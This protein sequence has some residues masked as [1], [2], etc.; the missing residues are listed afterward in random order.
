MKKAIIALVLTICLFIDSVSMQVDAEEN[1]EKENV[2][3][4]EHIDIG[5]YTVGNNKTIDQLLQQSKFTAR[6]GH[7][8]AA[9]IGNNLKLPTP[10]GV[11]NLEKSIL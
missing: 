5:A 6:Q 9:E 7:G 10:Y 3:N 8:F 1:R 2:V 11:L 4:K